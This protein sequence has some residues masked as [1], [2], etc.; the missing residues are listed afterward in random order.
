MTRKKA[1]KKKQGA[2]VPQIDMR[3]LLVRA[4]T[5]DSAQDVKAYLDAGGSPAARLVGINAKC[6]QH[7]PLLHSMV[8]ILTESWL[9]A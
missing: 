2:V 4:K 3:A 5:G 7:Y 1:Q 6:M 9:R 8:L